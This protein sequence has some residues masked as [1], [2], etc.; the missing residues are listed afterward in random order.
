MYAPFAKRKQVLMIGIFSILVCVLVFM[1]VRRFKEKPHSI[2]NTVNVETARER[3]QQHVIDQQAEVE[4][5]VA[6][7]PELQR[8]S[9]FVKRFENGGEWS[10]LITA[11]DMYAHGAF[12]RFSPNETMALQ[13]YSVAA[14]CPEP[15]VA[16]EAQAKYVAARL[17]PLLA[18]DRQGPLM[19]GAHGKELC[20][21]AQHRIAACTSTFMN[22]SQRPRYCAP[23]R[24]AL[25]PLRRP[26]RPPR[27]PD[28]TTV[29][30][31]HAPP[32]APAQQQV[33]HIPR[34]APRP[35]RR[36][37]RRDIDYQNV[38]D[39]GVVAA[40]RTNIETLKKRVG[41]DITKRSPQDTLDE[42]EVSLAVLP[43]EKQLD[44]RSV[45]RRLS[46]EPHTG[47]GASEKDVLSLVWTTIGEVENTDVRQNLIE[48]LGLQ[49]ADSLENGLQVCS[50]G[51]IS[52][53]I[54]AVEGVDEVKVTATKPV[55]A[56]NSEL[57]SLAAKIRED[58][59]QTAGQEKADEYVAGSTVISS[60]L[61][62]KF[63]AEASK[64][65][66][67]ELGMNEQVVANLAAVFSAEL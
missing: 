54:S 53:I 34:R 30:V 32:I 23:R 7:P 50:T 48:T 11:A 13:L 47:F 44:A 17:D 3:C 19:P 41:D 64:I 58:Y 20:Q 16:G 56:I 35:P 59:M 22:I 52:R 43:P 60:D 39:G 2:V 14:R 9:S 51:K 21:L 15:S 37:E 5:V 63:E 45:L 8:L 28:T 31:N 67:K 12:P 36:R 18:V 62:Q 6:H 66:C 55:W 27:R 42:V 38:H 25:E 33:P 61:K 57:G 10:I 49:L 1:F 46:S 26:E 4:Q 40:V 29:I 65:Y 24:P